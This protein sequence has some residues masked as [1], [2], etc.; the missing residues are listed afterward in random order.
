[1]SIQ[2]GIG[3]RQAYSREDLA[4]LAQRCEEWGFDQLWFGNHRLHRDMFMCATLAAVHTRRV[5]LGTFVAE[6]YSTHP[7]NTIAAIATLDEFSGGRA[8]LGLGAG[9]AGFKALGVERV[10][11]IVTTEATIQLARHLLRGETA[12]LDAGVV[13]ADHA[14]LYFPSRPTLPI[15]IASRG[16]RMLELGGRMADGVMIATYA[17]PQ[18]VKHA[19]KQIERGVQSAGRSLADLDLI[20]RV[21]ASV[22][23]DGEQARAAVRGILSSAIMASYPDTSFI[24]NSGLALPKDLEEMA[25]RKDDDLAWASGNLVPDEFVDAFAWAGTPEQVAQKIVQV[26]GLGIGGIT[27]LLHSRPPDHRIAVGEPHGGESDLLVSETF[28]TRVIPRVNQL[29]NN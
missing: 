25:S 29:M 7:G 3:L 9:G 14:H 23:E 2:W 12:T 22:S 8:I 24:R 26:V 18:G 17:T 6:P 28:A 15:V 4:S 13:R 1:M 5:K 21:D 16:D 10:K 19:L 11:P 27:V 20:V